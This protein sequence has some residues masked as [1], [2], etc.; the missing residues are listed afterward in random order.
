[1]RLPGG[2]P[3]IA[4]ARLTACLAVLSALASP[5]SGQRV[6]TGRAGELL[7][8]PIAPIVARADS[9]K[10]ATI[11]L[12]SV[13]ASGAPRSFQVVSISVPATFATA[14]D[15]QV[16]IIA[17]G[18][19]VVLGP[20]TRALVSGEVRKSRVAITIGIPAGALAGHL[21]AAEA[22]FSAP[23]TP[24]VVVPVD[25]DV[26]LVRRLMLRPAAEPANGQAGSDVV[27][28]FE[29]ENSG[30]A[31]ETVDAEFSLPSGWSSRDLRHRA[32]VI[33][34]GTT[35]KRAARVAIPKL[36]STGSSFVKLD[37]W[38]DG[39]SLA[40]STM[41]VEVVN[42]SSI[43]RQSGPN[44]VSALSQSSNENGGQNRAYSI[45]ANGALFDSVRIDARM[46]HSSSLGAA[47]S[48]S[49]ARMG[50]FVSSPSVVLSS[51][52]GQLS[53]GNTG[54]SFSELTGLYPYGQGAL[55]RIRKPDWDLVTL[56]AVSMQ[57]RESGKRQPMLGV[58]LERQ[59][60]ELRLSSSLSHL[61]DGGMSARRLDA[62]GIGAAIPALFGSTLKA[63]IAERRFEAGRGFGWS[64]EILRTRGGSSEQFR[65]THA[66]G[67]SDAFARATNEIVANVSERLGSRV[68]VS[69]SGWRTTDQTTVFSG[70]TSSGASL[71]PQY[72][73][74]PGATLALEARTYLF[75]ADSR[76]G[77]TNPA[78]S[79]GSRESQIGFSLSSHI[80]Q[81][82]VNTSAFLGNVERSAAPTGQTVIRDRAPR[83]YWITAAGWSSA[84]GL[85][86]VQSRIEQTRDR[87]GFVNQQNIYGLRGEQVM[88]GWLG[89]IR[90]EADLQRIHGFGS[91]KSTAMR[92][93]ISVPLISGFAL[94]LDAER[95]SI[96]RT[97]SGRTP[98]IF[99]TRIEHAFTLPMI[100][101]PGTTG[102]VYEDMNGNHRRDLGEAGVAGA[103]VRR[104]SETSIA[105]ENGKYRVG[106]DGAQ[107][108]VVDEASLPEGWTGSAPSR[109]DLAVSLSRSAQVEL[110]VA[111]RSGISAVEVDL[112]KAL[113]IA[114]DAAG[115]EWSAR[116]TG[117][118]TATFDALPV[119]VY[120][121][122]FDLTQLSEPLAPRGE[123]PPLVVDGKESRSLTITLDPRP[124]RMWTPNQRATTPGE[125]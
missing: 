53:L 27:L 28:R 108:V 33:E 9:A 67:G 116:M 90:A 120:T 73:I 119:G 96:F 38:D 66:P 25:I 2:F 91:E 86:E 97:T 13:V 89:G 83:N 3:T 55:F 42:A 95:N 14:P 102:Y 60:G 80:R 32:I 31:R 29:I 62:I 78:S 71:R 82:Y 43:G 61:A 68:M 72:D 112:T 7:A 15:P 50:T 44:I 75:D 16:E 40:S 22:R 77:A 99:G 36:S 12:P 111:P 35:V 45:T 39:G 51:P 84:G 114:R 5:A 18:E 123:V 17:H 121:L 70:L 26:S 106:G 118:S 46:S 59:L 104:G 93:G 37:L 56:G 107:P 79:F 76:A 23:G 6:T 52:S 124:I 64:T 19:F 58:R 48:N 110:V 1:M 92:G 88:V 49:F 11:T 87:G 63:E 21:R 4:I 54:T 57:P 41:T 117:P 34:P 30:N 8:S 125:K 94:K 65:V 74:Y 101:T 113:I 103:M 109:G 122:E 24:T 47:A 85:V 10:E 98:W 105:D 81:F 20:R 115:R 69:A 100:R